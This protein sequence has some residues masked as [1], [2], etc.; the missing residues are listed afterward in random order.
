MSSSLV[1][2]FSFESKSLPDSKRVFRQYF[3]STVLVMKRMKI[4]FGMLM[5]S[6]VMSVM[7]MVITLSGVSDV[8]ANL[9][10]EIV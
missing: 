8:E 1:E 9:D 5:L 6:I 2:S 3:K 10:P 4:I 7:P